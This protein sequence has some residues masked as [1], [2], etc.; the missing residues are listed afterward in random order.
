MGKSAGIF[1]VCVGC[2]SWGRQFLSWIFFIHKLLTAQ[3]TL[4]HCCYYYWLLFNLGTVE[5]SG[6][7]HQDKA[8]VSLRMHQRGE[9]WLINSHQEVV[10]GGHSEVGVSLVGLKM[11]SHSTISISISISTPADWR[12]CVKLCLPACLP[13]VFLPSENLKP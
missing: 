7:W 3:N 6:F 1:L 5:K 13:Q 9:Q 11:L 4:G 10:T 2:V 12:C 8:T